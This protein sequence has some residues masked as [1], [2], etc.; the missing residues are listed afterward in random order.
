MFDN[1]IFETWFSAHG[2]QLGA[3][4]LKDE[5]M[6]YAFEFRFNGTVDC[7]VVSF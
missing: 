1:C 4:H 7:F 5:P 6:F 2:V 3:C